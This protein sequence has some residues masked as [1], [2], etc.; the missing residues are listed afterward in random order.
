MLAVFGESDKWDS[1]TRNRVKDIWVAASDG[2]VG[3][4]GV[5]CCLSCKSLLPI[6][7]NVAQLPHC[8]KI[9]DKSAIK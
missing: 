5:F 4:G 9:N 7:A 2:G 8:H 1:G 3:L 6:T